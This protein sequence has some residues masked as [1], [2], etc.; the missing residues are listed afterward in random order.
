[1]LFRNTL[2][3]SCMCYDAEMLFQISIYID[4][5]S[6]LSKMQGPC[7]WGQGAMSHKFFEIVGFSETFM[8]CRKMFGLLMLVKIK[9]SNVIG[10]LLSLPLL[11]RCH[12]AS[13]LKYI[14]FYVI[15]LSLNS[16]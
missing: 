7:G 15:L 14:E 10:K 5:A 9:V 2:L 12:D 16:K 3:F 6:A 11:Y 8:F 1:M 4:E 13:V